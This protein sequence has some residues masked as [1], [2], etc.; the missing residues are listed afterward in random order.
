MNDR[1]T[2]V[3]SKMVEDGVVELLRVDPKEKYIIVLNGL[4]L[5]N[6]EQAR[7]V[8]TEECAKAGIKCVVLPEQLFDTL[9]KV[10]KVEKE[11]KDVK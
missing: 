6:F 11:S 9:Y 8:I 3:I 2:H 10:E 1:A 7:R 4:A 5:D